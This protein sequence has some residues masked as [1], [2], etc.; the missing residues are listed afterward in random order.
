MCCFCSWLTVLWQQRCFILLYYSLPY[1][2]LLC[3]YQHG[4]MCP[5]FF[6][7]GLNIMSSCFYYAQSVKWGL[8]S[9]DQMAICFHLEESTLTLNGGWPFPLNLDWAV[10]YCGVSVL[11]TE[12]AF[13]QTGLLLNL[14]K[15]SHI[16]NIIRFHVESLL[17][18]W[19]CFTEC[20]WCN[21]IFSDPL[22]WQV[23]NL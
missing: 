15:V 6:I 23:V 1:S 21:F 19:R 17:E 22:H 18:K 5:V 13:I 9:F 11:I 2:H 10:D 7:T 14:I 20:A 4:P 12:Q 8:I 16:L 3:I